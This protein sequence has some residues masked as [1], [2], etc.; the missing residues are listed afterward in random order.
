MISDNHTPNRLLQKRDELFGR[1]PK[2]PVVIRGSLVI[3]KRTC[4]K[5]NCRCLK[6]SPHKSLYISQSFKGK[7]RMT[8]VPKVSEEAVRRGILE[9]HRIKDILNE[10]SDLQLKLLPE[11]KI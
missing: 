5:S 11:G 8:Y 7:T 6:K 4:G 9:Y 1:L 2:R 10:L 3:M